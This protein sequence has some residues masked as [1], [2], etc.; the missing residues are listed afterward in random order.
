MDHLLKTGEE[1]KKF[2]EKGDSRSIYQNEL[3]KTCF[4]HDMVYGDFQDLCRGMVF[5]IV[6]GH[7]AFNIAKNW[8][9]DGYQCRLA[10]MVYKVLNKNCSGGYVTRVDKSAIKSEIMTNQYFRTS[11][12]KFSRRIA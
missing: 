7:K 10:S 2:K 12:P 3:D 1:H 8:R 11:L 5:D 9:Y 4:H 6:L